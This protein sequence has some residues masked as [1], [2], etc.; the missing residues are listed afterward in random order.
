[1]TRNAVQIRRPG[2][3]RFN[4]F[5]RAPVLDFGGNTQRCEDQAKMTGAR[6]LSKKSLI[7]TGVIV[8]YAPLRLC[9]G[10][11]R[12]RVSEPACSAVAK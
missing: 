12:E 3:Q 6:M 5:K 2:A 11:G 9:G 10:L 4:T 7:G 1:M 8:P